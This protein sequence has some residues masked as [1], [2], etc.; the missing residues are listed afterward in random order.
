MDFSEGPDNVALANGR[1]G[2]LF[3]GDLHASRNFS[4]VVAMTQVTSPLLAKE[5]VVIDFD[6]DG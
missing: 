3:G 6:R 4:T 1:T 2:K 5:I